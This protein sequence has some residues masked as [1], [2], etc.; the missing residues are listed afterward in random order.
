MFTL[1]RGGARHKKGGHVTK[2]GFTLEP[3]T[4]YT[5]G[6]CTSTAL[7][8][9]SISTGG[10][11]KCVPAAPLKFPFPQ[12]ALEIV[13]LLPFWSFPF[14]Q[15]A[16]VNW[17]H[18]NLAEWLVGDAEM[19]NDTEGM[20]GTETQEM[21]RNISRVWRHTA[22]SSVCHCQCRPVPSGIVHLAACIMHICDISANL[23]SVFLCRVHSKCV[24][25]ISTRARFHSKGIPNIVLLIRSLLAQQHRKMYRM[26]SPLASSLI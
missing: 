8:N 13:Y 25:W 6:N 20:P 9:I 14:P 24:Q 16:L 26:T 17:M 4:D 12:M 21:T 2:R 1:E 11:G 19:R 3:A 18:N 10:A 5:P 7:L 15:M 23:M 22:F